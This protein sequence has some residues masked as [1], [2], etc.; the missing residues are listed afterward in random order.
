MLEPK[1]MESQLQI[2]R[3]AGELLMVIPTDLSPDGDPIGGWVALTSQELIY[4][5][6]RDGVLRRIPMGSVSYIKADMLVG[7]GQF[8]VTSGGEDIILA[9]YTCGHH[10]KYVRLEAYTKRLIEGETLEPVGDMEDGVCPTCGWVFPDESRICPKCINKFKA[11]KRL[12]SVLKPYALLMASTLVIFWLITGLRL[13]TPQFQRLLIDGVLRPGNKDLSL[14]LTYVGAMALC[15]VTNVALTV[16]RGRLMVKLSNNLSRDL[17][18]MVY[19]KIQSLSLGFLSQKKTGDLMNRVTGDTNN[20]RGFLENHAVNW[21]NEG[22]ILI[23]VS[24]ILL[25]SNWKLALL[26]LIPAPF[27]AAY[28]AK[29]RRRVRNMF[30]YERRLWD[31]SNSILQDILSGMRVVK[32]FGQEEREV[33]HFKSSARE[34]AQTSARNEKIWNTIFPILGFIMGLG[35]FF[36]MYY[37]GKL[38]WTGQMK[39]G[40]LVQFT[41]YASMVYGPLQYLSRMPQRF[42]SAMTSAERVFE[43]IDE[44]PDVKEAEE[45]ISLTPMEGHVVF[46]GVT[47]GYNKYEPVLKDIDLYV[48]PGEMIGL[49]GH[50]GAGKSTLINL[51]CRFYDVDEGSITVDGVDIRDISLRDLRNQIGVVLQETFLFSGT[52]WENIA[53]SKP[54]ASMDEIIRAA[55][56]ANAH[57]FIIRFP[58]GYDTRVGDR[59]QRLSGGERQRIAIA[60]A[61]LH[62][63][64][65]LILDEATSSVD[66]ETEKQ[67]QEALARLT[68][69][70]TTFAIAHRLSTLRNATR[71]VVLDNGKIIE[72]GPHEELLRAEGTYYK[73]VMAQRSMSQIRWVD[74]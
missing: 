7:N 52:I 30:R 4:L 29:I 11:L 28:N 15:R 3:D 67:I 73:L 6:D 21:I 51:L 26:V 54:G 46:N 53:Y 63:P 62:D 74:G 56:I 38:V 5:T 27:V 68:K 37:G 16:V 36:V 32:A 10:P 34:Y 24:V 60:R 50:S 65:I 8:M 48:K 41:A 23:G 33:E 45:P 47:F 70:R 72:E 58:D 2:P 1:K 18:N 20:I 22:L 71:L 40:E 17:R 14:L 69:D 49:V 59:G 13:I 31:K 43:V 9:R 12:L 64:R 61:I 42:T 66:T 39:L 35:N 55:K 44:E 25:S 19:S 57:D